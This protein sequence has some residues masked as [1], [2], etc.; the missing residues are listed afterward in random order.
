[1]VKF[2]KNKGRYLLRMILLALKL[3]SFLIESIYD[4]FNASLTKSLKLYVMLSVLNVG[5]FV[6]NVL[7]LSLILLT[8]LSTCSWKYKMLSDNICVS[9]SY[10]SI[11]CLNI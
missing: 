6:E 11:C 8:P 7:T 9:I 3:I 1:M 10:L 4:A 2:A 5:Y